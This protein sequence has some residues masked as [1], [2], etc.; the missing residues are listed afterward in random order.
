MAR[1]LETLWY[2]RSL[3]NPA[4]QGLFAWMLFSHKLCRWLVPWA[5]VPVGVALA[6]LTPRHWW[7]GAALGVGGAAGLAAGLAWLWPD[8]RPLPR[9]LALPAY[10]VSGLVAALHAWLKALGGRGTAVWEPTRRE[11]GRRGDEV[12]PGAAP[13]QHHGGRAQHDLQVFER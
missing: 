4:R 13:A 5:L 6:W 2:K 8:G 11:E 10:A 7:A 9:F 3:L 1:G 12:L